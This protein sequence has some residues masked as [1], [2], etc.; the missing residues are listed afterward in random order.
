MLVV[1]V[2]CRCVSSV[3]EL[4][5]ICVVVLSVVFN[6]VRSVLMCVSL[7]CGYLFVGGWCC[8]V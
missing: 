6:V 5:L 3:T 1:C 7:F 2:V 4:C 8:C